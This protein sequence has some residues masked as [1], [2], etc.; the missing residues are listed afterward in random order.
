MKRTG[1]LK[2]LDD[3]SPEVIEPEPDRSAPDYLESTPATL[4]E[5][6]HVP[7]PVRELERFA[8]AAY[9]HWGLNE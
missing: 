1:A 9:L 4:Q 8:S 5:P 3:L 2:S 6:R 7:M